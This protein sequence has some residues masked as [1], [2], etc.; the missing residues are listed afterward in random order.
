MHLS[1][2]I[3]FLWPLKLYVGPQITMFITVHFL[4]VLH[5]ILNQMQGN[6]IQHLLMNLFQ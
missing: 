1:I 6:T 3:A 2:A 4:H 5:F